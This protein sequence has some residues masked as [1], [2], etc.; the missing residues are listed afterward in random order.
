MCGPLCHLTATPPPPLSGCCLLL[1]LNCLPP[2][3]HVLCLHWRP[4]RPGV[5]STQPGVLAAVIVPPSLLELC[6]SSPHFSLTSTAVVL[7]NCCS[8][9][10]FPAKSF[11]LSSVL[12]SRYPKNQR[13]NLCFLPL[14]CGFSPES[15]FCRLGQLHIRFPTTKSCQALQQTAA[16]RRRRPH[17]LLLLR[18]ILKL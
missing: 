6:S 17:G 3:T 5:R 8:R 2:I 18:S 12:F 9:V 4:V 15:S 11:H 13:P 14:F 16:S 10:M 1:S 7:Q